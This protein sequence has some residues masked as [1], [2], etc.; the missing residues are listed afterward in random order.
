MGI[1]FQFIL[2]GLINLDCLGYFGFNMTNLT[3][4][5]KIFFSYILL[6]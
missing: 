5:I 2:E 1:L 6:A 4:V 3:F